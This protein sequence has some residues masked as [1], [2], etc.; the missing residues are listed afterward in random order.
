MPHHGSAYQDDRLLTDLGVR[1]ALVSAG[2]H[3]DY[4][5]PDVGT[6]TRLEEAGAMVRR[7]DEH[8]DVAVVVEDGRLRVV[9]RGP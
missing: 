7:T 3:N 8:G 2:E 9:S 4:G 1:V 6:L 5:H